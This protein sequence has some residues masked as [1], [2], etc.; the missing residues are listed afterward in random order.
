MLGSLFLHL[1]IHFS[2]CSLVWE[3]I[4]RVRTSG[5]SW[6]V[7]QIWVLAGLHQYEEIRKS[8]LWKSDIMILLGPFHLDLRFTMNAFLSWRPQVLLDEFSRQ[9]T[10]SGNQSLDSGMG[11]SSPL[12]LLLVLSTTQE[13]NPQETALIT[14]LTVSGSSYV[15]WEKFIFYPS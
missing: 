9:P 4:S 7:D 11:N 12:L 5:F 1:H 6:L 10:G 15:R 8:E 13:I 14:Q 2:A 3:M